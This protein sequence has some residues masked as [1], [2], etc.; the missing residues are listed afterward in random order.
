MNKIEES[1]ILKYLS[2]MSFDYR[3]TL[4]IPE[5]MNFGAEI[6]FMVPQRNDIE[7]VFRRVM[8]SQ[9]KNKKY[10]KL[11]ADRRVV[12]YNTGMKTLELK[13][14]ILNNKKEDFDSLKNMMTGIYNDGI[15]PSNQKGIHV[16][17][18]M[19]LLENNPE[20][21]ETLL[22]IFCI[23]EHIIFRFSFGEEDRSNINIASY[24]REISNRLYNY[25]RKT[26]KIN[27]F[28]KCLSE[29][30][31]LF[32]CKSYAINFH[33]KDLNCKSDTIEIRPF[34]SSFNPI[35]IQNDINFVLSMINN[36]ISNNVDL[37]LLDYRFSEHD[38]GFYVKESYSNLH[39]S[40]AIEFSDLIF[41]EEIDKDYFLRQYAIKDNPRKKKLVI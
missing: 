2:E 39:L 15:L 32:N 33:Q 1:S 9:D 40:D 35:I 36:I 5:S 12:K 26:G 34:N 21:L 24:S 7:R 38:N 41:N 28:Y 30:R 31:E 11:T 22:K 37:E 20:Y 4:N 6:E 23:Y 16:H 3:E 10:Y 14:P 19:S 17:A 29:L 8:L 25:L 13:T 18:D 27:N